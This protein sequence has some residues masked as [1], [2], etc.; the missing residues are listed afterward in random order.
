[1]DW[2]DLLAELKHRNIRLSVQG[3]N[4]QYQAPRGS[5]TPELISALKQ[6]RQQLIELLETLSQ[7][8][9]S[10]KTNH[11]EVAPLSSAQKQIWASYYIQANQKLNHIPSIVDIEGEMSSADIS[12]ALI[13]LQKKHDALQLRFRYSGS[14]IQQYLDK[15]EDTNWISVI[16]ED[17]LQAQTE[18]F[19]ERRFE[20]LTQRPHRAIIIERRQKPVRCIWCFHH[21]VM[22]GWSMSLLIGELI[23]WMRTHT[24]TTPIQAIRFIDYAASSYAST[25]AAAEELSFWQT[26]LNAIPTHALPSNNTQFPASSYSLRWVIKDAEYL[27]LQCLAQQANVSCS[28]VLFTLYQL[29]IYSFHP[30]K[31]FAVKMPVAGR[32]APGVDSLIGLFANQMLVKSEMQESM[33]LAELVQL[34]QHNLRQALAHCEVPIGLICKQVN[35]SVIEAFNEFGFAYYND[36]S[37]QFSFQPIKIGAA[38]VTPVPYATK[39]SLHQ[40]NLALFESKQEILAELTIAES[41]YSKP[42]NEGLINEIM[43]YFL[44][45]LHYS[46]DADVASVTEKPR[47]WLLQANAAATADSSATMQ[48]SEHESF[49][50]SHDSTQKKAVLAQI[51]QNNL[52]EIW[53]ELLHHPIKNPDADFFDMGGTSLMVA[54]LHQTIRQRLKLNFDVRDCFR[55]TSIRSLASHLTKLFR[56]EAEAEA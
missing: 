8:D 21:L 24:D 48:H 13:R 23:N 41:L 38:M 6:Q 5:L 18:D 47:E 3:N 39:S 2:V 37:D 22:D 40:T 32:N 43:Q 28:A 11:D 35:A 1:M 34:S 27:S 4:L 53:E 19:I 7:P 55:Y 14:S 44:Q 20:L 36:F 9:T 54:E 42:L 29:L 12:A 10:I 50:W 49:L 56:T 31:R 25:N 17:D 33:P 45:C 15:T 30:C 16:E 26:Y 46:S 52:T 51:I